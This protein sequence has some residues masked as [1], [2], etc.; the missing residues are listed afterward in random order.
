MWLLINHTTHAHSEAVLF[1]AACYMEKKIA[2]FSYRYEIAVWLSKLFLLLVNNNR[3]TYQVEKKGPE[4]KNLEETPY[5]GR[6]KIFSLLY[7][8]EARLQPF[9]SSRKA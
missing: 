6:E 3:I 7:G 4:S 5:Y 8:A 9:C 2:L 1:F